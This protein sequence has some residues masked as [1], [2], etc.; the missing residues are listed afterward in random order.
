MDW[1]REF[2]IIVIGSGGS[3]MMAAS[4]AAHEG[5]KVLLVEKSQRFGGT[6]ALSGGCIWV[7]ANHL[8]ANPQKDSPQLA[9]KY[10]KNLTKGSVEDWLAKR[11][12]IK[13]N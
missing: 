8:Q 6:T 13:Y 1:S 7:P 3:G 2:D 9:L 10:L 4:R 11:T 12:R 5:A